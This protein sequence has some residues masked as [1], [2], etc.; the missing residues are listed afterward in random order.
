MREFHETGE[1]QRTAL[2]V[3][4]DSLGLEAAALR[5]DLAGRSAEAA[6]ALART[7]DSLLEGA[8]QRAAEASAQMD[9]KLREIKAAAAE[10]KDKVEQ[11]QARLMGRID[12]EAKALGA[13][14]D[15]LEK[16]ER[17][18]AAR[19]RVFERADELSAKLDQDVEQLRAALAR[20]EAQRGELAEME[21]QL[22][23]VRR[24]E[25]EIN[26]KMNRFLSERKRI[27]S[28]EE[29]F[30]RLLGIS[31]GIDAR[32]ESVTAS[33]DALTEIEARMRRLMEMGAQAET[34][35]ERLEKKGGV[36]DSTAE[37]IDRAF[38]G[39]RE[40]EKA[41]KAQEAEL[42]SLPGRIAE[43]RASVDGLTGDKEKVAAAV[44]RL[45]SLDRDLAAI[46]GRIAEMQKAREWLARTETR[47]EELAKEAQEQVRLFG[48]IMKKETAG[49]RRDQGA[50]TATTRD[51]VLKL[52]RQGWTAEE[53][54]RATKLSRG[55]VELIL[56][57]GPRAK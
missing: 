31:Q 17:D 42:K 12:E 10:I 11:T 29:D 16:R 1:A 2:S 51:S 20:A 48:D 13:T 32:L 5:K 39:M 26:Q 8:R 24:L 56:E 21:A 40:L 15:E 33:S 41:L 54:A 22:D 19:T 43:L 18:F 25:D 14:L 3:Q 49:S 55:E 47:L 53:I 38:Q 37:G 28:M 27:D 44:E 45:S 57:L 35:L 23:R 9:A 50:P 34:K 46:E 30:K 4:L 36:L 7:Y 52:S 6:E